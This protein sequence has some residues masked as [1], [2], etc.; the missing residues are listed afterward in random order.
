MQSDDFFS[1]DQLADEIENWQG[2]QSDPVLIDGFELYTGPLS[3]FPTSNVQN[4]APNLK[5]QYFAAISEETG[6]YV[7]NRTKVVQVGKK[8]WK[9]RYLEMQQVD[10][11]SSWNS[12]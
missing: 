8:H 7:W 12:F 9:L 11:S 2:N 4:Q 5:N 3:L 1:K 10:G 6:S